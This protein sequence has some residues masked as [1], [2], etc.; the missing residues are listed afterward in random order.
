MRI[1]LVVGGCLVVLLCLHMLSMYLGGDDGPAWGPIASFIISAIV[2][3]LFAAVLEV[4][5]DDSTY[6]PNPG[7]QNP[8]PR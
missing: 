5:T 1:A 8:Y 6:R 4:V 7:Y 2:A 3:V